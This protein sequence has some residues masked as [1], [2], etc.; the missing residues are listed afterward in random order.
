MARLV[1]LTEGLAGRSHELKVDR[2]T[3]GRLEDNSFQVPEGS[4]SSHHAEIVQQGNEWLVRD[5]NSTNGTFINGQQITEAV[6]KPGQVLRVGNVEMRLELGGPT[7]RKLPDKSVAIPQGIKLNEMEQ[8]TKPTNF[9]GESPFK[10]KSNKTTTVFIVIGVIMGLI[11]AG[12]I[13]YLIFKIVR[14]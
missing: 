12:L 10:K 13:T 11:I 6:L 2:T 3:I 14:L 4:V 9:V 1:L 8:G 7:T 5:L